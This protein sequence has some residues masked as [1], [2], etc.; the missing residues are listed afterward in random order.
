M[1]GSASA[2]APKALKNVLGGPL[3]CC[4]TS[5][6]TGY[7]RDGF[8][9]TDASD[10]GKHVICAQVTQRWLEF[11]R[12]RGNDLMT[13]SPRNNFPG[14]KDGDKWCLCASRWKEA[15][16]AGVAPP[17]FL[18]CTHVKALEYVTLESLQQ[19]ALDAESATADAAAAKQEL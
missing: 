14:L 15:Y 9:Q 16:D 2:A 18:A 17:V 10:H 1:S 7:Y 6:V 12:S 11:S 8:C 13:P 5:P 4:C 3:K 19:H